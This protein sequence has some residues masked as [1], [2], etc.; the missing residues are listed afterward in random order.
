MKEAEF[1]LLCDFLVQCYH[2]GYLHSQESCWRF[3]VV[4]VLEIFCKFCVHGSPTIET[5]VA[6]WNP[7][8]ERL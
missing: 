7:T 2:D 6:M 3:Y 4:T 8:V 1:W 5:D